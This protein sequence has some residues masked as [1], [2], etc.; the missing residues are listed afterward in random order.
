M[1]R[2]RLMSMLQIEYYGDPC[3]SCGFC[4]SEDVE[5]LV[6]EVQRLGSTYRSALEGLPGTARHPDLGLCASAYVAHVADNPRLHG[7]RMA[8]GARGVSSEFFHPSQDDLA[9][10][11]AYN[12][13]AL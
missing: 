10:I 5:S 12:S 3:Q 1:L 2:Y 13:M 9:L 11:R 4:W 8:A 7:E 6:A